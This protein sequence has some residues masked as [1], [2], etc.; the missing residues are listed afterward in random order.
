[1]QVTADAIGR[2]ADGGIVV[3]RH[4][5]GRHRKSHEEKHHLDRYASYAVA[6]KQAWPEARVSVELHY[7]DTGKIVDVTPSPTVV[8]NRTKKLQERAEGARAGRYPPNAGRECNGCSWNLIC[9]ASV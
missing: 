2:G 9:P 3:A 4:R 6:A 7:L 8:S 1:M 5:F